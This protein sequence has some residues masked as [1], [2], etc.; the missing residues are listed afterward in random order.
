MTTA[1]YFSGLEFFGNKFP[2]SCN[3]HEFAALQVEGEVRKSI[4]GGTSVT[5]NFCQCRS[6]KHVDLMSGAFGAEKYE[7]DFRVLLDS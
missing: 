6:F 3:C 4:I 7:V 2:A 1:T 5:C